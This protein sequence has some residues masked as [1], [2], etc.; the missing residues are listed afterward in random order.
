MELWKC[1]EILRDIKQSWFFKK[2]NLEERL[3]ALNNILELGYNEESKT[4]LRKD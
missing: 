1:I 4:I 3:D 2:N